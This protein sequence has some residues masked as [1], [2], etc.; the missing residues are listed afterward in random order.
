LT[1]TAGTAFGMMICGWVVRH[2]KSLDGWDDIRAYRIIFF[3][4]AVLGLIKMTLALALSKKV[5]A[6]KAEEPAT[7][8]VETA[9]LLGE[10]A[11]VNGHN[12]DL[13]KSKKRSFTSLLPD[14]SAESRIIIFSLCGLFAL[15]A[16]AS[17]LVPL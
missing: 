14:I 6:E 8:D 4:Y 3:A 9:P 10:N 5:E 17:G 15:D 2:L 16:F 11:E 13:K 1:G 7:T 12:P